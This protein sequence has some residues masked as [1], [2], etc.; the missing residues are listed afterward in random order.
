MCVVRE[1]SAR[2]P[3]SHLACPPGWGFLQWKISSTTE[4]LTLKFTSCNAFRADIVGR[5]P[6]HSVVSQEEEVVWVKEAR[7]GR[8][9][10]VYIG[11]QIL[12]AER[13]LQQVNEWVCFRHILDVCLSGTA[14]LSAPFVVANLFPELFK[15]NCSQ[16]EVF[17]VS[18]SA[19]AAR[20]HVIQNA[21]ALIA[22]T[23]CHLPNLQRC[24]DLSFIQRHALRHCEN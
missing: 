18:A 1:C 7:F 6:N 19:S 23:S 21:S 11:V 15:L 2:S 12:L 8:T 9:E 4:E 24:G 20:R 17:K 22:V 13:S 10:A 16:N 3:G 14:T 5:F